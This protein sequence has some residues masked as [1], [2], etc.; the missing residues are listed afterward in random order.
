MLNAGLYLNRSLHNTLAAP[1]PYLHHLPP[2]GTTKYLGNLK[3]KVNVQH[4]FLQPASAVYWR[5][6]ALVPA[7]EPSL[8]TFA[9]STR[10][11]VWT[12]SAI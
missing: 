10:K 3:R 2:G 6:Q 5:K 7:A 1:H 4:S 11:F 8:T 9:A 12:P